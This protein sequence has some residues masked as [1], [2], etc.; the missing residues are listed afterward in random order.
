ML[1]IIRQMFPNLTTRRLG[2]EEEEEEDEDGENSFDD[3]IYQNDNIYGRVG[4]L[5]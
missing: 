5:L 2:E 4:E 3:K 1:Q